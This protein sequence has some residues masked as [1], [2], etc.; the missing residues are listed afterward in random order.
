[1]N[2]R[3]ARLTRAIGKRFNDTPRRVRRWWLAL[4]HARRGAERKEFKDYVQKN[5]I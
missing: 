5:S 4:P 2:A 1:M 3:A